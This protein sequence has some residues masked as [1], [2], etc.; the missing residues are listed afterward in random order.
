MKTRTELNEKNIVPL[1]TPHSFSVYRNQ[2]ELYCQ[3]CLHTHTHTQGI[4]LGV[5]SF[6]YRNNTVQTDNSANRDNIIKVKIYRKKNVH[7]QNW[8]CMCPMYRWRFDELFTDVQYRGVL[9]VVQVEYGLG[10][11]IFLCLA[12]QSM[13]LEQGCSDLEVCRDP[14]VLDHQIHF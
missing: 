7:R 13:M 10:K 8:M 4:C 11:K 12:Y 1:Q 9:C 6:Q 3:V 5:R 14:E 2:K